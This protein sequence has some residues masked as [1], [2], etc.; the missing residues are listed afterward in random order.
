MLS[1]PCSSKDRVTWSARL[2]TSHG[3]WDTPQ[4]D[5][6]AEGRLANTEASCNVISSQSVRDKNRLVSIAYCHGTTIEAF[7]NV[8]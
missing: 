1:S 6:V 4:R 5:R 2:S 8:C 7:V 3:Q